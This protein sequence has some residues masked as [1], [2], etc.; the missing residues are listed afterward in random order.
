[1]DILGRSYMLITAG[2]QGLQ[3][4]CYQNVARNS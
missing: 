2:S 1:M 3:R 4:M